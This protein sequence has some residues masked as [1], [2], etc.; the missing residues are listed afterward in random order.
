MTW[1]YAFYCDNGRTGT[2]FNRPEFERLMDDVRA[3]KVDCIVVKDLSRFG[4]NYQ[5]TGN[6]LERIF[7]LLG[8]RFIA[9]NDKFDTLTAERTQDGYIVPL[10][11]I[12]N[13]VYSKDISRKI[14]P[15][16]AA[17][18]QNGEFI[19]S[20]AAYGYQK[21]AENRYRIEPNPETAPVVREMFQ[22]RLSGLNYQNI[23]RKL[24]ERNIP[25]PARY[26]YLRGDA[27]SERY[28]NTIWRV[29]SV[30]NILRDEV[31]Q[32]HMVQGRKRSGF[33][34]GRKPYQTPESEWVI[35]RNTHEPL[36]DETTFRAVQQMGEEA[37]NAYNA[38]KG[39]Y[40]G[41]GTTPNIFRGLIYCADCGRPLV[42][43]KNVNSAAGKRY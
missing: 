43:Y 29:S 28:A 11:N 31:Y 6:Y 13:A 38:R 23:A 26:H 39:K 21:C 33:S 37:K 2:N 12:M 5:E 16:L 41:L 34:E 30:K 14:L 15:A 22:W 3:G 32:G 9:V 8:V 42:R 7:P 20:W 1:I 18:Q 19:G 17:K 10:K 4:R 27:K 40:D 36:V 25:S 24:N 35:V